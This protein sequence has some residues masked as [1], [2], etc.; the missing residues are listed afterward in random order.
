MKGDFVIGDQTESTDHIKETNFTSHPPIVFQRKHTTA[1]MNL[2]L[3]TTAHGQ[4]QSGFRNIEDLGAREVTHG[5]TM[6]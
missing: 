6:N 3:N 1:F 4:L 2:A 5:N